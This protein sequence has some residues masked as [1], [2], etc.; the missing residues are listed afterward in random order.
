[1]ALQGTAHVALA[2]FISYCEKMDV[3]PD[4]DDDD[5]REVLMKK[6]IKDAQTFEQHYNR[7]FDD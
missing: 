7:R 3:H 1:M 5:I 2:I 4:K 6:A